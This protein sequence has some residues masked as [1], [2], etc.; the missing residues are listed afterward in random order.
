MRGITRSLVVAVLALSMGIGCGEPLS[1]EDVYG[2]WDVTAINGHKPPPSPTDWWPPF[3]HDSWSEDWLVRY[4]SIT[5][6]ADD[7]YSQFDV[8]GNGGSLWCIY[9]IDV[10][11]NTIAITATDVY[12]SPEGSRECDHLTAPRHGSVRGDRMTLEYT[13]GGARNTWVLTRLH[14]SP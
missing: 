3:H 13:V 12:C 4:I 10:D 11:E 7:C 1:P 14:T 5:F 6:D 8:G 2:R 9:S